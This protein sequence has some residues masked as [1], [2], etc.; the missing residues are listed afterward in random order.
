MPG[1]IWTGMSWISMNSPYKG[2]YKQE[3]VMK[4]LIT[5]LAVA[6]IGGGAW[7]GP[8]S[9][10]AGVTG[11]ANTTPT[12]VEV[13]NGKYAYAASID[14][15][16][17]VPIRFIKK[18]ASGATTNGFTVAE[19]MVVPAT[20]SYTCSGG[21]MTNEERQRTIYAIVIATESGEAAYSINFE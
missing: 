7:A 21:T 14:N 2:R 18:L 15:A 12:V 5:L 9:E 19:A 17:A 20:S 4:K 11:T 10:G 3:I 1:N 8:V 13:P 16:G 6:F